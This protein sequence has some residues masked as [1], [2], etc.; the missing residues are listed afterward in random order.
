LAGGSAAENARVIGEVLGGAPGPKRDIVLLNA[1]AGLLAGGAAS[2]VGE[3]LAVA[4]DSVDSGRAKSVL[5]RLVEC[6][7]AFAG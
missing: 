5:G 4:A 1:A 2:D 7:T 6:S 3:G